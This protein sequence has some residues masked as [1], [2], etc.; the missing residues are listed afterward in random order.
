MNISTV[1]IPCI[2]PLPAAAAADSAERFKD[3][4]CDPTHQ[5]RTAEQNVGSWVLLLADKAIESDMGGKAALVPYGVFNPAKYSERPLQLPLEPCC[6][7]DAGFAAGSGRVSWEFPPR[8]C[9]TNGFL[10]GVAKLVSNRE[11]SREICQQ[12]FHAESSS[13]GILGRTKAF[14][15]VTSPCVVC[16]STNRPIFGACSTV[17]RD[18]SDPETRSVSQ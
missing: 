11:P 12:R 4:P 13:F 2:C 18:L 7:R 9:N 3:D 6:H 10:P 14:G 15:S 17:V 8:P 16:Q 5:R 1:R